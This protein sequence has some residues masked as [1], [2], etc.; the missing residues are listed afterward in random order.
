MQT[1]M[2]F[3]VKWYFGKFYLF[4]CCLLLINQNIFKPL[5]M[6]PF[7]QKHLAH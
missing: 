1:F 6:V 3:P 4:T 5:I 2:E 7:V